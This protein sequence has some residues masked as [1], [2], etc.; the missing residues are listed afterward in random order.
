MIK[1]LLFL[2]ALAGV[3]QNGLKVDEIMSA[4]GPTLNLAAAGQLDMATSGR[5]SFRRS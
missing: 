1:R 2:A 4:M 3:A 5:T